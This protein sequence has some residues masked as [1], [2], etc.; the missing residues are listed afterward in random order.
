MPISSPSCH[1]GLIVIDRSH[2]K[3]FGGQ[4][5]PAFWMPDA[6]DFS[7]PG[8]L[9]QM[10]LDLPTCK[11]RPEALWRDHDPPLSLSCRHVR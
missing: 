5:R 3:A 10:G 8:L 6:I 11:D 7:S 2:E 1:E 9:D 4:P